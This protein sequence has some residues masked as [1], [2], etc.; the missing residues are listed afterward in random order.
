[1][2]AVGDIHSGNNGGSFARRARGACV[3]EQ[4]ASIS[5]PVCEGLRCPSRSENRTRAAHATAA[6]S[7]GQRR[8]DKGTGDR[9]GIVALPAPF[10]AS[11]ATSA[12]V[13][14]ATSRFTFLPEHHRHLLHHFGDV[15]A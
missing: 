13:P 2:E 7:H 12:A 6:A 8:M 11:V 3:E 15:P 5:G 4:A 14:R 10:S 1:M 9:E